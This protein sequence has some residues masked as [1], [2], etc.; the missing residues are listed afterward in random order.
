[1]PEL[2]ERTVQLVLQYD[3]SGFSGWQSQPGKRT[4]Q[5]AVEE[6]L[7]RLCGQRVIAVGAGRTDAGVHA[8]G[9]AV[10]VRVARRWDAPELRRAM[11]ALLPDDVWVA[12]AHEMHPDF[13]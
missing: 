6:V 5:G 1:M 10:G 13:H 2:P 11:N 12:A 3:G 8:R 7:E 9:L 4:V